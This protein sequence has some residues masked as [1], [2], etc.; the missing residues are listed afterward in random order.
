MWRQLV[1]NV[2]KRNGR[3]RHC[4][5]WVYVDIISFQHTWS[6][7][8]DQFFLQVSDSAGYSIIKSS[9][10]N[11]FSMGR[12]RHK[13]GRRQ[14]RLGQQQRRMAPQPI[15]RGRWQY[16]KESITA[17]MWDNTRCNN[18]MEGVDSAMSKSSICIFDSYIWNMKI[19]YSETLPPMCKKAVFAISPKSQNQKSEKYI[20]FF[21]LLPEIRQWYVIKSLISLF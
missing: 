3:G 12:Q 8:D 19:L 4:D 1:C 11:F 14:W 7:V 16:Q 21:N 10:I 5:R 13:R 2:Q 6:L 20:N 18:G 17:K 9:D 15:R